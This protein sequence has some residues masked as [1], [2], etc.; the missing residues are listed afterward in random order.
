MAM[1]RLLLAVLIGFAVATAPVAA[2]VAS[3]KAAPKTAME[4]CHGKAAKLCP[5]CDTKAKKAKC[6]GDG[7]KCCK[8]TGTLAALPAVPVVAIAAHQLPEPQSVPD[9]SLRPQ[10][11]PPRS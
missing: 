4:D 9:R 8:L 3:V 5:D 10:I 11:P 1:F 7:S 6:P 2:A